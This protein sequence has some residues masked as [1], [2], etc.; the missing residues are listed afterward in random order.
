MLLEVEEL[1]RLNGREGPIDVSS[2]QQMTEGP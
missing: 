1:L 2:L